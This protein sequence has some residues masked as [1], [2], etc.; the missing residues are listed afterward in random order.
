M[1]SA[2]AVEMGVRSCG[3][4]LHLEC[5]HRYLRH[6]LSE[7]LQSTA[8]R[9]IVV[10]TGVLPR[11]RAHQPSSAP[12]A[13]EFFCPLCRRL[14]NALLP[15]VPAEAG[16]DETSVAGLRGS[17][18]VTAMLD[19]HVQVRAHSKLIAACR[20][21][22]TT[23][24]AS[25]LLSTESGAR[26]PDGSAPLRW[27]T[28]QNIEVLRAR[29]APGPYSLP[30]QLLELQQRAAVK[31]VERTGGALPSVLEAP[32][33]PLLR[34]ALRAALLCDS[35]PSPSAPGAAPN[36]GAMMRIAERE[37]PSVRDIFSVVVSGAQG[38][39]SPAA[40]D[41]G[42]DVVRPFMDLAAGVL[43]GEGTGGVLQLPL[44]RIA[45]PLILHRA[46]TVS[47]ETA[48]RRMSA[49]PSFTAAIGQML[50]DCAEAAR[51]FVPRLF[52]ASLFQTMAF[53]GTTC[54]RLGWT[55]ARELCVLPDGALS[56]AGAVASASRAQPAAAGASAQLESARLVDMVMFCALPVMRRLAL[57]LCVLDTQPMLAKDGAV[58]PA[59]VANGP[60]S[61]ALARAEFAQLAA[62]LRL[63]GADDP[64]LYTP[65]WLVGR[66]RTPPATDSGLCAAWL[67]ALSGGG[68][69]VPASI[70]GCVPRAPS[71]VCWASALPTPCVARLLA[72]TARAQIELPDLYQAL[73]T[74][75]LHRK[76]PRCGRVPKDAAICLGALP[77]LHGRWSTRERR[78]RCTQ[79]AAGSCACRRSAASLS[80]QATSCAERAIRCVS[81]PPSGAVAH[82]LP[83][84]ARECGGGIGV[85]LFLRVCTVLLIVGERRGVWGS[86]YLDGECAR[87]RRCTPQER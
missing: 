24:Q 68:V 70:A 25:L 62:A 69:S 47:A 80:T 22:L 41:G 64:A 39:G 52:A 26:W 6:Q 28:P 1:A 44:A 12:G 21:T 73:Y 83:Q 30:A 36:G 77:A 55:L 54:S 46:R 66:L 84:H 60:F 35:M 37:E 67:R 32:L 63:E 38:S 5:F 3:H 57:L 2:R 18:L 19:F 14:G 58:E 75:F 59:G 43:N 16:P 74:A 51:F 13:G 56:M 8:E 42:P 86:L 65:S 48:R 15:L 71:L 11:A 53:I 9:T 40:A 20:D 85:F 61:S 81:A 33:I 17:P 4:F 79:C 76:C 27:V 50:S 82:D 78:L 45:V 23:A 87:C 10:E 29:S 34:H 49:P 31:V 7:M 72:L